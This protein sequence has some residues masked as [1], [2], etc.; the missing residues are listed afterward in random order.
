MKGL[1]TTLRGI[2]DTAALEIRELIGAECEI[3][4]GGV[5]FGIKD[6]EDLFLLC[7]KAQSVSGIMLLLF[8]FEAGSLKE[9]EEDFGKKSG[10]EDLKE[11]VKESFRVNCT[12]NGSY[13]FSGNELAG[14]IGK[15]VKE[16]T[17]KEVNLEN[18]EVVFAAFLAGK[19]GHFGIDFAGFDLSKREYNI[20]SHPASINAALAYAIARMSGYGRK[21]KFID[22]FAKSGLIP[23]EAALYA[24]GFPVNHYRKD[25][26]AFL[27]I[28]KFEKM[29]F[30]EFFGKIDKKADMKSKKIYCIDSAM[31]N[32][33]AAEK[34]AKIAGINKTVN[35]SRIDV[36]W[37]D[38]K[39]RKNEID[40]MATFFSIPKNED[41]EKTAKELFYQMEYILGKKGRMAVMTRNPEML[42]KYASDYKFRVKERKLV[43]RGEE[44]NS[45]LVFV[46]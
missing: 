4:D 20:F 42:E 33:R 35:F 8:D 7:Y 31:P 45:I 1:A 39:F 27:P 19:K 28:K 41:A 2:E 16:R 22:V 34:N 17:G 18:P 5:V 13:E 40:F 36:S 37:L 46:K 21:G 26:F 10:K 3:I 32:V 9:A 29:K 15:I 30:G 14:K 25:K 12:K 43:I 38:T 44:K 23:I 11:W 6:Y 24:S